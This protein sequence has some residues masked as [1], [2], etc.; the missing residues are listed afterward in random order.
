MVDLV[1]NLT[2]LVDFIA[3]ERDVGEVFFWFGGVFAWLEKLFSFK[4]L[5]VCAERVA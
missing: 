5:G 2:V 4:L 1:R 3:S